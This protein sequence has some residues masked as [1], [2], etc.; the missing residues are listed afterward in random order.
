MEIE[1]KLVSNKSNII[2]IRSSLDYNLENLKES[3]NVPRLI[4]LSKPDNYLNKEDEFYEN[5]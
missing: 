1:Y 2:D 5:L 3:I 4:L